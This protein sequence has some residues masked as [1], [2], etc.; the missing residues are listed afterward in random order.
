MKTKIVNFKF[1]EKMVGLLDSLQGELQ[2]S[3]R[4][5][6]VRRS[7]VLM[8]L[9]SEAQDDGKELYLKGGDDG[10]LEKIVFV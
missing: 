2:L 8:K 9:V 1:D 7:L 4:A 10:Q 5:A 3:S 6:V